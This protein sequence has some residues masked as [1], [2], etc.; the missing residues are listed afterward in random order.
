[1][2]QTLFDASEELHATTD[3][4]VDGVTW[5]TEGK[6]YAMIC[7]G[8]TSQLVFSVRRQGPSASCALLELPVTPPTERRKIKKIEIVITYDE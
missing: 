7:V 1:M 4:S 5:S 2:N 3:Y 6:P 8:P